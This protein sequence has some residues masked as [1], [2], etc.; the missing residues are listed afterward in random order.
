LKRLNYQYSNNEHHKKQEAFAWISVTQYL[1]I[2]YLNWKT[3]N[4]LPKAKSA[5]RKLEGM[6]RENELTFVLDW[7]TGSSLCFSLACL[8]LAGFKQIKQMSQIYIS[9][10]YKLF[11]LMQTGF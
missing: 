8:C 7:N 5:S 3:Q 11:Q 2:C 9:L 10:S 1:D 4:I 6:Q